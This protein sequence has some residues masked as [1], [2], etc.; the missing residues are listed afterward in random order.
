M[1]IQLLALGTLRRRNAV[2]GIAHVGAHVVVPVLVETEGA[3]GV[4]N[5]Q[6][7]DSNLELPQ[8]GQLADDVVRHE[9]GA[10]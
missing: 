6:I 9:V 8:L 5:E 1:S 2:E 3:T 10:P 7:Q 4:L